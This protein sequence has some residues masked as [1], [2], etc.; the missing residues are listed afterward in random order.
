M[1]WRSRGPRCCRPSVQRAATPK[2]EKLNESIPEGICVEVEELL[3]GSNDKL[4]P[5]SNCV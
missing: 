3:Y 4:F 1:R 5:Y 2:R